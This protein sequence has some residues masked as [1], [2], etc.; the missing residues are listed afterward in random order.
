MVNRSPL[1]ERRALQVPIHGPT[2]HSATAG[3]EQAAVKEVGGDRGVTI[4]GSEQKYALVKIGG[5]AGADQIGTQ[6]L[7]G[8]CD[9]GVNPNQDRGGAARSSHLD[10][11]S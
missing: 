1:G 8:A 3:C 5:D 6:P 11:L 2:N 4:G 10:D 7:D 9:V